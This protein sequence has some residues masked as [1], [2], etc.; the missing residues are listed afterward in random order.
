M[1]GSGSGLGIRAEEGELAILAFSSPAFGTQPDSL[2]MALAERYNKNS[3]LCEYR[4]FESIAE[5]NKKRD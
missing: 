2:C 3:L 1:S 5:L 4:S